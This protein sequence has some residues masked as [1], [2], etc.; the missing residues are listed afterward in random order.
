MQKKNPVY[1]ILFSNDTEFGKLIRKTTGQEFSHAAISL[2]PSLNKMYS[3]GSV[4]YSR[5]LSGDAFV[6]ESLWSPGY[7]TNRYF[8]VYT[9]FVDD[10]A[11]KAIQAKI[12]YFLDNQLKFKYNTVGLIQYYF[13][14][15]ETKDYSAEK[16]RSWF[17]SEFVSYILQHGDK[18]LIDDLMLSPGDLEEKNMIFVKQ[19]TIDSFS[20]ADLVK[21]TEKVKMNIGKKAKNISESEEFDILQE[22]VVNSVKEAFIIKWQDPDMVKITNSIDWKLLYDEYKKKIGGDLSLR[23]DY[24]ELLIHAK[25]TGG[26][27]AINEINRFFVNEITKLSQRI[28]A[29]KASVV[30][31]DKKLNKLVVKVKDNIVDFD[32]FHFLEEPISKSESVLNAEERRSL[33]KKE[34]GLPDE[35]KFPLNDKTHVEQAI[36]L[37]KFCP[38]DKRDELAKNIK[39]AADKY[40]VT[41]SPDSLLGRKLGLKVEDTELL[42]ESFTIDSDGTMIINLREKTNFMS[43]YNTSQKLINIY[44]KA[45][46]TTG[47]KHEL[48]KLWFMYITIEKYYAFPKNPPNPIFQKQYEVDKK[49]ALKAKGF[50]M[51]TFTSALKYVLEKEPDFDFSEYFQDSPYYRDSL[52]ISQ[53]HIM[54]IRKIIATLITGL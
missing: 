54:G 41:V 37:F 13:N 1:V 16:K 6:V 21:Q 36:K 19:Y 53:D 32:I 2:D 20:E 18:N 3:F 42:K 14:A 7:V 17:C 31:F 49:E 34:F 28:K 52:K 11:F 50:I 26:R 8:K 9:I 24:F 4:P 5:S 45:G 47:I 30:S 22:G 27:V 33:D 12:K 40:G 38:A 25:V 23:F 35:R 29:I 39:K 10:K 15:K 46:N 51:N 44:M 43:K 48:C